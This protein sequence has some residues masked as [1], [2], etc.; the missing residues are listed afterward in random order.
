MANLIEADIE[1]ATLDWLVGVGRAV[2]HGPDL[3]SKEK[4]PEHA[5][6]LLPKLI[7]GDIRIRDAKKFVETA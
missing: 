4:S 5:S 1:I 6:H 3:A 2:A 7:S